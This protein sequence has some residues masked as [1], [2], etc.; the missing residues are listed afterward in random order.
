MRRELL[1]WGAIF[2]LLSVALGAFAAHVIK[3]KVTADILTVFETA[4]RYQMYHSFAI[5]IAGMLYKDYPQKCLIWAGR[6]FIIGIILF[7]GSLFLLTYIKAIG[8]DN[9]LWV[10]AITPLG[11]IAFIAGWACILYGLLKNNVK[12]QQ[13]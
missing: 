7:S 12:K 8:A 6:L 9:L 3:A 13:P 2:A 11:G 1:I 10:G 5:L 4:V